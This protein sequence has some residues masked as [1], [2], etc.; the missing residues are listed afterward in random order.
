MSKIIGPKE[1]D[2]SGVS[3]HGEIVNI[4]PT[5]A[6]HT[7]YAANDAADSALDNSLS[8]HPL[9]LSRRSLS[10]DLVLP[11]PE[12]T[13]MSRH[14]KKTLGV[15]G[16]VRLANRA[17]LGR[18]V[19][20]HDEHCSSF[21]NEGTAVSARQ[22]VSLE[23]RPCH[24][25][26]RLCCKRTHSEAPAIA[27]SSVSCYIQAL[28][29]PVGRTKSATGQ[30]AENGAAD[31]GGGGDEEHE[32]GKDNKDMDEDDG[33][34]LLQLMGFAPGPVPGLRLTIDVDLYLLD[35]RSFLHVVRWQQ[36]HALLPKCALRLA[37][38]R[39]S[40][41]R[42]CYCCAAKCTLQRRCVWV[43]SSDTS[44]EPSTARRPRRLQERHSGGL[45]VVVR[46]AQPH[47]AHPRAV[48][49]H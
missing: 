22:F 18:A 35:P 40:R 7:F 32:N 14:V 6:R 42:L 49:L 43:R 31:S 46:R 29:R 39:G 19:S 30:A 17:Y 15:R 8:A 5:S 20:K 33:N 34:A 21:V 23:I 41:R 2:I 36:Q 24:G 26:L 38:L 44:D 1:D 9:E 37:L 47:A 25:Q 27:S 10:G 13:Y 48:V 12:P 3:A 45:D 16:C 28:L 11:P 4:A